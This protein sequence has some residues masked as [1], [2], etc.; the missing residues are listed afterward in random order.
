MKWKIW[1]P[2]QGETEAQASTYNDGRA[3]RAGYRLD[4]CAEYA[5]EKYADN[6]WI[7]NDGVEFNWPL[8][9]MVRAE[10]GELFEV[11]VHV[12]LEPDFSTGPARRIHETGDIDLAI[13]RW[14]APREAR[15]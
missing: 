11:D 10:S 7:Y 12:E 4:A 15:A 3:W 9:F 14:Y 6:E 8:D 1:C 5:A 2:E 13:A